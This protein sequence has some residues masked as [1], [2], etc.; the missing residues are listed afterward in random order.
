M[1]L[2]RLT[3]ILHP[4]CF[5]K[6]FSPIY[7]LAALETLFPPLLIMDLLQR[8]SFWQ[9]NNTERMK[10]MVVEKEETIIKIN[11][12]KE[13]GNRKETK[14]NIIITEI[15]QHL[16]T[17]NVSININLKHLLVCVLYVSSVHYLYAQVQ[18]QMFHKLAHIS[19]DTKCINYYFCIQ[20]SPF[21]AVASGFHTFLF[22]RDI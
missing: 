13:E 1:S 19:L 22:A 8:L 2:L 12:E 15:K 3:I 21:T 10:T 17:I 20:L 18:L 16:Q 14:T 5:I 11:Q 6:T 7:F 4:F 9:T